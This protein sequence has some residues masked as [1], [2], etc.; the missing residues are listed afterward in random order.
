MNHRLTACVAV[1]LTFA[2]CGC[3]GESHWPSRPVTLICPW[4]AGGGTDRVA[5]QLAVQLE[6]ELGVPV[7]VV[8]ATGGGGATGHVRGA[9]ARP[10]GY[11]LT[12]ATV[13]LNMLHWRGLCPITP[14]DFQPIA[15][16]NQD[17]AA[18]FVRESSRWQSIGDLQQTLSGQDT[19]LRASGTSAGG[20]W[21][22]SLVG[23]LGAAD[24]P[25]DSVTW[26][27]MSGAAPSLQEL[28]AGGIELVCC[29]IPE[30]RPLLDAGEIRCLAVMS[31]QRSPAAPDVPTLEEQGIGWSMGGWRGVMYPA[32]V[33]P[34]KA[35]TMQQAVLKVA[36]SQTFANFMDA[37]GFHRDVADG[38]AFADFLSQSDSDFGSV[39]NQPVM[40]RQR[41]APFG[42]HAFPVA[43]CACGALIAGLGF[44]SSRRAAGTVAATTDSNPR[45]AVRMPLLVGFV[46]SI[47]GFVLVVEQVGYV[48]AAFAMLLIL[49]LLLR[50]S[51]RMAATTAV[52]VVAGLYQVFAGVLG[53]PL[54]W[55]WLGW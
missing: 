34:E 17:S 51:F 47:G 9:A 42:P 14:D 10:D 23:W 49:M 54:P 41:D 53:V 50:V 40:K 5:R 44:R 16:L 3:R 31:E 37:A 33:P 25:S 18:I 21:H 27:S 4:S 26:V 35:A 55:G 46:I 43:V 30:A 7:N 22:V 8:N 19:P 36:N 20:I 12:M 29:S 2:V 39:L 11:T 52:I 13:E 15:K 6:G 45:P 32:G 24:L 38:N 28:M 48:V 1:M